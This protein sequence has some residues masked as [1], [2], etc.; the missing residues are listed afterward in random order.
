MEKIDHSEI[1]MPLVMTQNPYIVDTYI[2]ILAK[3]HD[4]Q[5]FRFC[6][7]KYVKF[8]FNLQI[9]NISQFTDYMNCV[10]YPAL[11]MTFH[12]LMSQY[13]IDLS[14]ITLLLDMLHSDEGDKI[15]YGSL[16]GSVREY[17]KNLIARMRSVKNAMSYCKLKDSK[18]FH[19]FTKPSK[20]IGELIYMSQRI[21]PN[22]LQ[23]YFYCDNAF[24]IGPPSMEGWMKCIKN[25]YKPTC[26]E[27]L[28][29]YELKLLASV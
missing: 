4:R 22:V 27:E 14:K 1:L 24:N 9:E 18:N 2:R 28:L 17:T 8:G 26:S 29:K 19:S 7:P 11:Y 23:E 16:D 21:V 20:V 13:N 25:E 6:S 3:N 15:N 12:E 5:V 10:Y